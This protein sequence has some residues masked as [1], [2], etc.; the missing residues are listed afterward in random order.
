MPRPIDAVRLLELMLADQP[1]MPHAQCR[2]RAPLFDSHIDGET[3]EQRLN[4]HTQARKLCQQ[5]DHRIECSQSIG[6]F[7]AGRDT[8]PPA[9]PGRP[10]KEAAA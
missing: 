9:R 6:G 1:A 3:S 8:T 10:N 2:G 4:R 7:R 5:C